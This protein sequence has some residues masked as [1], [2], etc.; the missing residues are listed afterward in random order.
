MLLLRTICTLIT[1]HTWHS[2]VTEMK[3]LHFILLFCVV[4]VDTDHFKKYT[5]CGLAI[6]NVVII[7]GGKQCHYC[8]CIIRCTE[9]PYCIA[10]EYNKNTKICKLLYNTGPEYRTVANNK[11]ETYISATRYVQPGNIFFIIFYKFFIF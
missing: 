8:S 5:N 4:L 7:N 11:K 6:G 1:V 2:E 3:I 10:V 9:E